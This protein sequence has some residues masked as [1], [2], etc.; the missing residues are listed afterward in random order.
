M[1]AKDYR[2]IIHNRTSQALAGSNGA[3]I[4][5]QK[6]K[7]DSSNAVVFET[8]ST[9]H[10]ISSTAAGA[11]GTAGSTQTNGT[12]KDMGA[13]LTLDATL[14]A[15]G[16]GDVD[17]YVEFS[18]DGGTTWPSNG[19]GILVGT[20]SFSAEAGPKAVNAVI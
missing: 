16:T 1:L 5:V 3:R 4:Y 18:H 14:A 19:G 7:M 17:F 12:A 11:Y 6:W 8:G 15:S 20:V 13:N 9:E 10:N 2:W